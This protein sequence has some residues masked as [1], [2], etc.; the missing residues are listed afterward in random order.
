MLHRSRKLNLPTIPHDGE[1]QSDGL[2]SWRNQ[3][4]LVFGEKRHGEKARGQME[5]VEQRS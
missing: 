2:D 5:A 1:T 4:K 3:L